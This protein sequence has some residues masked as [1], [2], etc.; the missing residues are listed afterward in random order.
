MLGKLSD[1]ILPPSSVESETGSSKLDNLCLRLLGWCIASNPRSAAAAQNLIATYLLQHNPQKFLTAS[2][3]Q[4]M[5]TAQA[6][7][8]AFVESLTWPDTV[9]DAPP[10]LRTPSWQ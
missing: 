2:A 1:G 8:A 5:E 6:F 9:V 3:Q 7:A 4:W 10:A